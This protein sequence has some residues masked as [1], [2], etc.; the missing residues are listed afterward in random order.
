MN[1]DEAD[2]GIGSGFGRCE[3]SRFNGLEFVLRLKLLQLVFGA[4]NGEDVL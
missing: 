2:Q 4:Q 3:F 1:L